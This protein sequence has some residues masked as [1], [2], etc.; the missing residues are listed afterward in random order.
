[1][2]A[3]YCLVLLI[4]CLAAVRVLIRA[5]VAVHDWHGPNTLVVPLRA[6]HTVNAQLFYDK[7]LGIREED[8]AVAEVIG[9]APLRDLRFAVPRV[10]LREL[11]F[12]PLPSAGRFWIGTPRLENASGRIIARFSLVAIVPRYQIAGLQREGDVLAGETLPD[13]N[14][15]QL[16][17]GLGAP[18]RVGELRWPW[19]NVGI[20]LLLTFA[21][22][23]LRRHPAN[24]GWSPLP[25]INI[26]VGHRPLF[27][28]C[29]FL[30][31]TLGYFSFG[32]YKNWPYKIESD[33]KYYYQYLV[34]GWFDH[35]LDFSNNYRAAQ[36]PWMLSP[37]DHYDMRDKVSPKTGRP[38]NVFSCGPAVLWLPFFTTAKG[39]AAILNRIS[40]GWISGNPWSRF[41]QYTVMFSAV[42]YSW[43]GLM[44]LNSIWRLWFQRPAPL[45]ALLLTLFATPLCYYAIFEVSMSHAYDFF[46]FC[47]ILWLLLRNR[48]QPTYFSFCTLG[49]ACALHVL[50]RTQN[51]ATVAIV[52]ALIVPYWKLASRETYGR[53]LWFAGIVV[54]FGILPVLLINKYLFGYFFVA[55]QIVVYGPGFLS[56]WHPKIFEVLFSERNGLFSYHPAL[57]LGLAGFILISIRSF[58]RREREC[59]LIGGIFAAFLVQIYVDSTVFD[60]WSGHSFGQRRLVGMLP[61]FAFG[62]M[63]LTDRLRALPS[64]RP[65]WEWMTAGLLI[66]MGIYLMFI[67]VYLWDYDKPHNIVDWM[68]VRGPRAII[69]GDFTRH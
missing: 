21:T 14:D 5:Y 59:W 50:V 51:I 28:T 57:V 69:G 38:A 68:A 46:T 17:I 43:I 39:I 4:L 1:M 64:Y 22:N 56:P 7:G 66:I 15:P 8:S 48:E 25:A 47:L 13:A 18:L 31:L 30:S 40:P 10:P 49:F 61:L 16:T 2:R 34:S 29:I 60:W 67:H 41:Y 35:D 20:L 44:F 62:F 37:I 23:W 53:Y 24:A 11:R 42:V 27:L 55:P 63:E 65:W 45:S 36:L 26:R 19:K 6:E 3:G 54:L 33:G 58:R 32:T 52:G 12:D 9:G